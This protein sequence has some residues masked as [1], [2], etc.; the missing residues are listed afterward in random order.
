MKW[1]EGRIEVL[2]GMEFS[3]EVRDS[4]VSFELQEDFVEHLCGAEGSEKWR[5]FFLGCLLA[6]WVCY[7]RQVDRADFPR[8]KY[9]MSSAS[10]Y[11]RLWLCRAPDGKM[12]P[13]GYTGWFPISKFVYEGMLE[14]HIGANDRGVFLPQ[15]FIAPEDIRYVYV[16]NISVITPL[17]NTVCSR[18]MIKALQRDGLKYSKAGAMAI[19]VDAA[20]KKFSRLASFEHIGDI[21]VQGEA[22]ALFVRPPNGD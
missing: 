22:E 5:R 9:I 4:F 1:L 20:G 15:R 10:R 7:D 17:R 14:Y 16:F 12:T 19:T 3:D 8:M 18:R 2:R 6:D 13:V 21:K 11:F